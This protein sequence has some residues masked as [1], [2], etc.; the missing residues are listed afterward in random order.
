MNAVNSVNSNY[1]N[2]YQASELN[3]TMQKNDS[4]EDLAKKV[5]EQ[6]DV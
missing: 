3:S 2:Q 5:Y 6:A 1:V 4:A